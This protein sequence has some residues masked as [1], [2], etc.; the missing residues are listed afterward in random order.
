MGGALNEFS[1]IYVT[2]SFSIDESQDFS[3]DIDE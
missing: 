2:W 1:L 3:L